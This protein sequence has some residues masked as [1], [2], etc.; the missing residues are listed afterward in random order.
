MPSI[1]GF[2]G[3]ILPSIVCGKTPEELDVPR[4]DEAFWSGINPE[5]IYLTTLIVILQ[6]QD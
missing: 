4:T 2:T 6:F 1:D 5:K 3:P